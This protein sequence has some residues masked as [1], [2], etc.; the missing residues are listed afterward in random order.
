MKGYDIPKVPRSS[1]VPFSAFAWFREEG[2]ISFPSYY[3][4]S[5]SFLSSSKYSK[6]TL[7]FVKRRTRR[8]IRKLIDFA[9][10][11]PDAMC[12]CSISY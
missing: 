11:N 8:K 5:Y 7:S 2:R 3:Y 6:R 10:V 9:N 12:V 1:C 4:F